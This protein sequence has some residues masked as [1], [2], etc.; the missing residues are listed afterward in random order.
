M[1]VLALVAGC[2]PR[3]HRLSPYDS[4]PD[5]AAPLEER[6]AVDCFLRRGVVPPHPFK[7]D[8]CSMWPDSD[9]VEC[10]ITHDIDYW[11]GGSPDDRLRADR[12]FR[13]CLR[14]DHGAAV[15]RI[16]YLGVRAGGGPCQP[17]P[18][19]WSYGW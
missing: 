1:A 17:F 5:L 11:C 8:G 15:A 19:R 2:T 10:C 13:E 3:S 4:D 14:G 6:A 16:A 9:W 7:T 18:W 12:V